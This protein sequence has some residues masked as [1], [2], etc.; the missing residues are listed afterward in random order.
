M[1]PET[2]TLVNY[3]VHLIEGAADCHFAN[4]HLH[5]R[6]GCMRALMFQAKTPVARTTQTLLSSLSA[7]QRD[8]FIS[9]LL[10]LLRRIQL[11]S[12]ITA[13]DLSLAYWAI[14]THAHSTPA[15]HSEF[16]ANDRTIACPNA[17]YVSVF[18]RRYN[19]LLCQLL[20]SSQL[21]LRAH[22]SKV[23]LFFM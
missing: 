22:L 1:R 5:I 10:E 18:T 14:H 4:M 7:N 9:I 8:T 11:K 23:H 13:L 15:S 2:S 16:V 19:V 21:S 6:V 20:R 3:Y 17:K 12:N